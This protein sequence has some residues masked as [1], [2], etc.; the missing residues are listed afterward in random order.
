MDRVAADLSGNGHTALG[1]RLSFAAAGCALLPD[2]VSGLP[3]SGRHFSVAACPPGGR[4]FS[5]R[6]GGVRLFVP[7]WLAD[8]ARAAMEASEGEAE[9]FVRLTGGRGGLRVSSHTR[10]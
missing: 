9:D 10:S 6:A 3:G 1:V 5:G 8:L 2:G 7:D 4:V